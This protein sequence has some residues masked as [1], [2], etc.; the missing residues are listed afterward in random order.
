MDL[1]SQDHL[2]NIMMKHAICKAKSQ[3]PN[4]A[5][6]LS[7]L[8]QF[9]HIVS[10]IEVKQNDDASKL[11]RSYCAASRKVRLSSHHGTDVPIKALKSM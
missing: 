6:Q 11:L 8:Q 2:N 5:L 10:S 9:L 4:S 1:S 7:N 3:A